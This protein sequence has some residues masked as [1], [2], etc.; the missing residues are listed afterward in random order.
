MRYAEVAL[1]EIDWSLTLAPRVIY[2]VTEIAGCLGVKPATVR[3]WLFRAKTW[4]AWGYLE[5]MP[6]P[7]DRVGGRPVWLAQSVTWWIGIHLMAHLIGVSTGDHNYPPDVRVEPDDPRYQP[8]GR[9]FK[10][11]APLPAGQHVVRLAR[12]VPVPP[13]IVALATNAAEVEMT[14]GSYRRWKASLRVIEEK[15]PS[16]GFAVASG[17][18]TLRQDYPDLWPWPS[19][20]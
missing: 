11:D 20:T 14:G 8:G 10:A 6:D 1:H 13:L 3:Q 16:A 5:G 17:V 19:S 15:E 12:K 9:V 18:R 4:F 7:D 2:G